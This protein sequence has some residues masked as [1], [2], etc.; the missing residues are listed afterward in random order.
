[1]SKDKN[2]KVEDLNYYVNWL[3]RSI[4]EE[5]IELYEYSDFE[6]IQ[7]IGSGAYGNV[8]RANRKNSSRIFAL[9]SFNYEKQTLKEVVKEVR[10]MLVIIIN[11]KSLD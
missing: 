9:K 8:Y 5:H 7:L 2:T 6:N 4:T 11:L 1:M 10:I 3:E